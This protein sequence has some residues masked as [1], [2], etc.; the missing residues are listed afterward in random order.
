[1][2]LTHPEP[3][4]PLLETNPTR[5]CELLVGLPDVYVVGIDDWPQF[6]RVAIT[7]RAERPACPGCDG[8]VWLHDRFEVGLVDLP[9]FGRRTR[10]V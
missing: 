4:E 9:C 5:M 1:M 2:C 10:L 7:T 3:E 6:L 8:A